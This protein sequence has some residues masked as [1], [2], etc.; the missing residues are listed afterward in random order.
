[1]NCTPPSFSLTHFYSV[2]C[3]PGLL[4]YLMS[5]WIA[6]PPA[7][8]WLTCTVYSVTPDYQATW[9]PDEL[10]TAQ[11][12]LD[13]LVQCTLWPRITELPDVQMNCTPLSLSLTHLYSVL[14][15]PGLLSYLM[16]RYCTVPNLSHLYIVLCNPDNWATWC[17]D[18]Q[19]TAQPF[20]DPLVQ[21]T[22][23]PWIAEL[24]DVQMNCTPPQPLL[25][26]LVQ[27]T[28]WPRI[29][30]LPDVQMN[31]TPP[32]LSLTPLYSVLCDPG[33]LNYLMSRWTV[34][35]LA[36]PW[37]TRTVYSL[38]PGYWTTWCPDELYAAQPLLDPLVQC[39]LWPR[40]TE[41]PD[42]QMNC[43]PPSLSL[44][45]SYSARVSKETRSMHLFLKKTITGYNQ[46][47]ILRDRRRN[48][49]ACPACWAMGTNEMK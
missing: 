45:H 34:R 20:L 24:P 40:I 21:G 29:T 10:Y 48:T 9:C 37:P 33:L 41:L 35:R 17:P 14:C 2:L 16:S 7:S 23:W 1:M 49:T 8:P 15:D 30:E 44:T 13:S 6:R 32:S 28:L 46:R 3:D 39:T 38:T 27:C 4:N 18:E 36:S 5:I 25:D 22:L 19:Y 11:P 12:L 43:T 26:P 31:C 42:V 47:H